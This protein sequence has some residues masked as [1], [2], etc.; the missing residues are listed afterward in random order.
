MTRTDLTKTPWRAP[1]APAASIASMSAAV[2]S[3]GRNVDADNESEAKEV[4][5]Y[6]GPLR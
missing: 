6:L 1:F 4:I 3:T 5:A 2:I